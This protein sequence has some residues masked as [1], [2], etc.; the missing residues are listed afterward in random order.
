MEKKT[1]NIFLKKGLSKLLWSIPFFF[2]GPIFLFQSFKNIDHDFFI[3]VFTLGV[4]L[5]LIAV[6]NCF[7]GIKFLLNGFL[8]EK[9]KKSLY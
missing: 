3:Y 6:I 4:I 2:S 8:G 7:F 5:M 1:N 9:N